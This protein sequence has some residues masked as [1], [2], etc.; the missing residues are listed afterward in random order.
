MRKSSEK[1]S[2]AQIGKSNERR[3]SMKSNK[4]P[5]TSVCLPEDKHK[6]VTKDIKIIRSL[7][8][9]G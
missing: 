7:S 1:S 9:V 8:S 3:V 2:K 6:E 5:D 4:N